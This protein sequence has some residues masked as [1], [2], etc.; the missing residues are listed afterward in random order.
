LG[1][2]AA[3]CRTPFGRGGGLFGG[4]GIGGV[5]GGKGGRHGQ[6]QPTRAAARGSLDLILVSHC[7][8]PVEVCYGPAEKCLTLTGETPLPLHAATGGTGEVFVTLK[9]TPASLFADATFGL[10]EVDE[11]CTRLR[12]R[13]KP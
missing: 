9:G 2:G 7:A 13:L 12:R 10:V 11:S 4:G 6:G 3:K 1:R 5:G 8:Q